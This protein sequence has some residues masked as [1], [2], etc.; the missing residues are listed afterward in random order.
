MKMKR[1]IT[2]EFDHTTVTTAHDWKKLRWCGVCETESEFITRAEAA[3]LAKFITALGITIPKD[4][5][6][7]YQP[8][9]DQTLICLNSILGGNYPKAN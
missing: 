4:G 9:D 5:T 3:H 7:F 1:T 8:G 6:H 2:I